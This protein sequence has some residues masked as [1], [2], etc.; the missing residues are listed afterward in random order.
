MTATGDARQGRD[1]RP[2]FSVLWIFVVLNYLYG[3]LAMVIFHPAAYQRLAGGMNQWLVLG[4]A[5]FMEVPIAMVLFSRVA[6]HNVNRWANIVIGSVF[7]AFAFVTLLPG[8]PPAFYIFLSAVEIAATLFIVWYAWTW[9]EPT[10]PV[11]T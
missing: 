5:A 6:S 4:A 10:Y 3:D 11:A 9:R 1:R 7:S 2:V 8:P